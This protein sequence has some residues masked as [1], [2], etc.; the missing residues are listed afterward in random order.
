[1]Q[2]ATKVNDLNIL[3]AHCIILWQSAVMKLISL[4]GLF[5]LF[6]STIASA[7]T[8][9][10]REQQDLN[11]ALANQTKAVWNCSANGQDDAVL[12]IQVNNAASSLRSST[13]VF[14]I[15]DP[16][17]ADALGFRSYPIVLAADSTGN[18]VRATEGYNEPTVEFISAS[19]GMEL[20]AI[21]NGSSPSVDWDHNWF[22]PYGTCTNN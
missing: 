3:F 10:A 13:N 21:S 22:F 16:A 20:V 5:G 1:M 17:V 15:Q 19:N 8:L 14:I 12:E 6:V 11:T 2:R 7:A 4:V 18:N 9:N